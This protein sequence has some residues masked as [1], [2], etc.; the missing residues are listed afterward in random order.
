MCVVGLLMVL[1]LSACGGSSGGM[2][3]LVD[4]GGLDVDI[5]TDSIDVMVDG[6]DM[7]LD[8]ESDTSIEDVDTALV[9]IDIFV[10][11]VEC[12]WFQQCG[13][14]GSCDD[15]DLCTDDCCL[16]GLICGHLL[17]TCQCELLCLGMDGCLVFV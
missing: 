2:T 16:F 3:V 11:F 13:S 9:D 12:Q 14:C 8:I 5:G 10:F 6:V 1:F 15:G 17:L 7:L 4:S